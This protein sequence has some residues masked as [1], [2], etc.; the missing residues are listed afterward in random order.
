M[1]RFAPLMMMLALA[2]C[3]Q[4]QGDAAFGQK[5]RAYLLENPE[6]LSEV[7]AKLD[8][9]QQAKAAEAASLALDKNRQALE[10]DPRDYVANP[11]GKITVVEFFDYRCGY[12]KLATPEVNTLIRDNPDV[13]FVFKELPIL[14]RDSELAARAALAV[15]DQPGRYMAVHNA[16]MAGKV[17]N[18]AQ[19]DRVVRAAG[20]DPAAVKRQGASAEVD[21]HLADVRAL[22]EAVGVNGTPAF[23]VGD[24]LIAGADMPALKAAIAK[25]KKG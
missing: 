25:A 3:G 13:R 22:A 2:A 15:K 24:T 18:E 8:E 12:C 5:V 11:K 21:R 4:P 10:R 7:A 6:V 9:R 23:I 20:A 16:L 19:I 14:S 17:V 1:L